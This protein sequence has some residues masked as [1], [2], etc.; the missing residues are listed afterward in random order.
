MSIIGSLKRLIFGTRDEPVEHVPMRALPDLEKTRFS[1]T[2]ANEL[3]FSDAERLS[4]QHRAE[5]VLREF[6]ESLNSANLSKSRKMRAHKLKLAR[7]GLVEL[8]ALVNKF[9]FLH[10]LNMQAV[11]AS[12]IA[13]EAET[14]VLTDNEIPD[15][16]TKKVSE[17]VQSESLASQGKE[18]ESSD[19]SEHDRQSF[20]ASN[21]QGVLVC[22][23]SCFRVVNES[24]EIARKSKNLEIKMSRLGVARNSLRQARTQANQISLKVDG[25]DAAEAEIDRLDEAIK[26]G[27]PTEIAGMQQID[28]NAAFSSAARNVLKDATALKREK[29]F[30][31]A[32]EKLREAYSADGAENLMIED[33]LRLPMYLQLAG[34]NDA[35][36]DELNRLYGRYTDQFSRPRIEHQMQVFLRKENNE[37]ALNPV[38]K[39]LRDDKKPQKNVSDPTSITV[40]ELQ[41]TP[42]H[43]SIAQAANESRMAAFRA[44][45]DVVSGVRWLATLDAHTC[46]RCGALDGQTWQLD[47]T[48][49]NATV[50]MQTPPLHINCRC[51]LSPQTR[52]SNMGGGQR[53][54]Q[55][56]PVDRKTTYTDFLRGKDKFFQD[57]V[58]GPGRAQMWREGLITLSQLFDGSGRELTL[59][60]LR[61]KYDK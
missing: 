40:G 41:N 3:Q 61:A 14:L 49:I 24:I 19:M 21:E 56:G 58:L 26:T 33:R 37:T 60:E 17:V 10:L 53:A 29:K 48:P 1:T 30:V 25:F 4:A 5:T 55:D 36:W 2:G 50:P 38:R 27:T 23:Q 28:T 52:F 43:T 44:N 15:P 51:V 35:G 31:E 9:P 32:C 57:E 8:K 22:I 16:G 12:I 39:F 6:N 59:T 20:N 11:E 34:K 13:V 47:G 7:E 42:M 18:I 54:S 45:S 46:P